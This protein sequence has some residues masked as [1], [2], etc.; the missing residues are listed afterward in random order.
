MQLAARR[1][2]E[3]EWDREK[4]DSGKNIISSVLEAIPLDHLSRADFTG[5]C[6][7][8]VQRW[9]WFDSMREVYTKWFRSVKGVQASRD[10]YSSDGESLGS[11]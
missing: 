9:L 4:G 1:Y 6:R 11:N 7:C 5:L 2:R 8:S 3:V 10:D